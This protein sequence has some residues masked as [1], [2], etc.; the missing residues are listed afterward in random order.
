MLP[1][2]KRAIK[3]FLARNAPKINQQTA[4]RL[5]SNLL[6][7]MHWINEAK[8]RILSVLDVLIH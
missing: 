8:V 2:R 7:P 1:S 3:D 6:I 5:S 4:M